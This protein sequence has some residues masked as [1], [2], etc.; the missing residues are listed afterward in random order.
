MASGYPDWHVA[1][2]S[3]IIA[4]SLGNIKISIAEQLLDK[5]KMDIAG[6]SVGNLAMNIAQ[7]DLPE[8]AAGIRTFQAESVEWVDV[9]QTATIASNASESIIVRAP[10]GYIYEVVTGVFFA[11][12]PSGATTGSHSI[13]ID[14]ENLGI[15]LMD[16][17]SLY[18]DALEYVYCKWLYA[19]SSANPSTEIGQLM[20]IRGVRVDSLNGLEI[21]YWNGT[22]VSQ[23]IERT[24][25]L[26]FRKIKVS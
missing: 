25:K 17:E 12:P 5:L 9:S 15:G 24:Y 8:L 11:A 22:D 18:S 3:D 10:T 23:T 4:Q 16:A 20:A 13:V 6:Q 26:W 14:S 2:K 7:Q 1:T 19:T 21:Y